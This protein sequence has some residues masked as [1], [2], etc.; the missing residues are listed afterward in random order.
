MIVFIVTAECGDYYCGCGHGH[1]VGVYD[2]EEQAQAA[3]QASKELPLLIKGKA[4]HSRS[5][6]WGQRITS[7]SLNEPPVAID[8]G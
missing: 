5:Y 2:S 1:I 4:T 3:A 7:V 6:P 8:I